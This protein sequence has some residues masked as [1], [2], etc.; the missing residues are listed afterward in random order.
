MIDF[1]RSEQYTLSIRLQA[2][3]FCFAV[4]AQDGSNEYA[5]RPYPVDGTKTM[6]ANLKEAFEELDFLQYAYA[7]VNVL[8][9]D[10][11]YTLVPKEHFVEQ[12]S[13]EIYQQNFSQANGRD[14]ILCNR[15]G[16]DR[17]IAVLFNVDRQLH[18]LLHS[19]MQHVT[20]YA[21]V[22][23]VLEFGLRKSISQSVSYN[24]LHLS[25]RRMDILCLSEGEP[26]LVNTF[27]HR[28]TSDSL[29]YLLNC[30]QTLGLSQTEDTLWIAGEGKKTKELADEVRVFV[31][32][33]R[34]LSAMEEFTE[35][36]LAR[37]DGVPF[38]LQALMVVCE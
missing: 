38:D 14:L 23:P 16:E 25:G 34:N 11:C 12:K 1:N 36:E 35:N 26:L 24:L 37:M 33:V 22:T 15:V 27:E 6:V 13:R 8:L 5:Y 31:K 17:Q 30:W 7:R 3:G 20:F 2:G 32:S 4:Y 9:V 21:S 18:Q 19:R 28:D 10:S 29:F